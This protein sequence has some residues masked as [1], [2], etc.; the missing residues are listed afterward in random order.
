MPFGS[1]GLV[2]PAW[3]VEQEPMWNEFNN[4]PAFYPDV[5]SDS[6]YKYGCFYDYRKY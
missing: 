4:D 5:F 1:R 3:Q 2:R 6:T